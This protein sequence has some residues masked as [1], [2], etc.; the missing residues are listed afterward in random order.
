MTAARMVSVLSE[1]DSTAGPI[2][3]CILDIVN[4]QNYPRIMRDCWS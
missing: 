4:V 3:G 2:L 1:A